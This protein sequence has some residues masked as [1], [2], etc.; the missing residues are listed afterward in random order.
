MKAPLA[1]GGRYSLL[2]KGGRSFA[3]LHAMGTVRARGSGEANRNRAPSATGVDRFDAWALKPVATRLVISTEAPRNYRCTTSYGSRRYLGAPRPPTTR[4]GLQ[5]SST[6]RVCGATQPIPRMR[7]SR[8][9]V[10]GRPPLR[11]E[12]RGGAAG[13]ASSH[14]LPYGCEIGARPSR[15]AP[16]DAATPT[17][18]FFRGSASLAASAALARQ[19]V[20]AEGARPVRRGVSCVA[21]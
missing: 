3:P 9:G 18:L 6:R 16:P 8:M 10:G 1:P 5:D 21:E 11:V 20:T 14:T 12:E 4:H 13:E 17:H 15:A 19:A 7:L 2:S